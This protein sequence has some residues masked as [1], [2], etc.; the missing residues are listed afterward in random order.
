[1]KL[2]KGK[3]MELYSSSQYFKF[4]STKTYSKI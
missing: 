1:M 3:E 4:I 2:R